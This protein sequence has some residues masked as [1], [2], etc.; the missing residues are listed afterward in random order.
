MSI[1]SLEH[2]RPIAVVRGDKLKVV[3]EGGMKATAEVTVYFH[4]IV[5]TSTGSNLRV[6][7]L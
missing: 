3:F 2:K 4:E 1:E 7:K 6:G 5:S